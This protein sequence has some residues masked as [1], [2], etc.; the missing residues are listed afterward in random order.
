M[1]VIRDLAVSFVS[2]RAR[3]VH[4]LRFHSVEWLTR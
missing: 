2:L 3:L 1:S 4:P